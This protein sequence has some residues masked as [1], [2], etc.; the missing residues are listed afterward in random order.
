MTEFCLHPGCPYRLK[1]ADYRHSDGNMEKRALV[2]IP[3]ASDCKER[4][5]ITHYEIKPYE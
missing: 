4:S 2:Y 1:Y 5:P 3:H